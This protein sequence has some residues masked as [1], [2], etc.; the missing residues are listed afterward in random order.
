MGKI[1]FETLQKSYVKQSMGAPF[2]RLQKSA[3]WKP[4]QQFWLLTVDRTVDR[5]HAQ[6]VHGQGRSTARDYLLSGNG[7]VDR[8]VDRLAIAQLAVDRPVDPPSERSKI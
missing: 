4:T 1:S 7:P 3:R 2:Y 5:P 8:A 6:N